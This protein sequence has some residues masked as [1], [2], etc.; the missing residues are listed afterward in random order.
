MDTSIEV[1]ASRLS[2]FSQRID[3]VQ[4]DV[5]TRY[6]STG[7]RFNLF[8]T[9]LRHD[10]EVRLHTRFLH[11][12]LDP[13]GCH[14]GGD[15]FLRQFFAVLSS[16]HPVDHQNQP[17]EVNLTETSG[18]NVERDVA[19]GEHGIL[20]IQLSQPGRTV[21]IENKTRLH[22]Q[23]DQISRYARYLEIR[24]HGQGGGLLLFLTP[25]GTP[26]S[27][28]NGECYLR[29]SY[30]HHILTWL[31]TCMALPDIGEPVRQG[32]QQYKEVVQYLVGQTQQSAMMNQLVDY[33]ET[34]SDLLR[35]RQTIK[36]ALDV[37]R[38]RTL[39]Q[40]TQAV[41]DGIKGCGYTVESPERRS[42][43]HYAEGILIITPPANS[44]LKDAPFQICLQNWS[45]KSLLLMGLEATD[46]VANK[47][48]AMFKRMTALL[49]PAG[50]NKPGGYSTW[51]VGW[52]QLVEGFNDDKLAAFLD[53]SSDELRE[54]LVR[55]VKDKLTA[56]ADAYAQA[57]VNFPGK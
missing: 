37:A 32:I 54:K 20:D 41:S 34:N 1:L 36:E 14:G 31:D 19:C 39:E 50:F 57:H 26:S 38:T 6:R 23:T 24:Q 33:I 48:E 28:H 29:I 46:E 10:D 42:F 55:T 22:E 47:H 25:K 11:C 13:D 44:P 21:I 30:H 49:A 51:P 27:T 3:T 15:A 8:T 16:Q 53:G 17:I 43:E 40:L 9:L 12:L 18:W 5:A 56:I 52:V 7:G 45:E 35:H 4:D 2:E